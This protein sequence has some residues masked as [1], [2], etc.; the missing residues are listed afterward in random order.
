MEGETDIFLSYPA[1]FAGRTAVF[2]VVFLGINVGTRK[3][4]LWYK[5]FGLKYAG[6]WYVFVVFMWL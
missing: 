4:P 2:N 1:V 3:I 6:Y 5:G